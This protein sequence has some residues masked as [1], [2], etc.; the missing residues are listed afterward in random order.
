MRRNAKEIKIDAREVYASDDQNSSRDLTL[1]VVASPFYMPQSATATLNLDK[2]LEISF[3]Y[4]SDVKTEKRSVPISGVTVCYEVK[5]G[6]ITKFSIPSRMIPDVDSLHLKLEIE[7]IQRQMMEHL[8]SA[9]ETN[10]GSLNAATMALKAY[11]SEF[12]RLAA[13]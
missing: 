8:D 1:A 4:D 9:S 6:R 11:S 2:D 7:G 5:T 10:R 3:L 13:S 12:S